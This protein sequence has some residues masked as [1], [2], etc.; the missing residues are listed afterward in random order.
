MYVFILDP[1]SVY[2]KSVFCAIFIAISRMLKAA[3]LMCVFMYSLDTGFKDLHVILCT[4]G[5]H[6]FSAEAILSLNY[7]NGWSA[8]MKIRHRKFAHVFLQ[9]CGLGCSV[10][11]T[12]IV[13]L[14]KGLNGSPHGVTGIVTM[15][16]AGLSTLS[17]PFTFRGKNSLAFW[18]QDDFGMYLK[19]LHMS[20]GMPTFLASSVCLCLGF[21]T[22]D[23]KTWVTSTV[24]FI[25]VGFVTFYTVFILSNVFIK[26]VSRF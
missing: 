20:I 14:N 12:V 6:F 3:T 17:G 24:S 1:D 11:G 19:I 22:D 21:L 18:V 16:L 9:I 8:P 2:C 10:A 23:F 25:L 15:V 5:F 13:I 26:C 7:A 4:F